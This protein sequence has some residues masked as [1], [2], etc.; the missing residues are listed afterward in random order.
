MQV[1]KQI[2]TRRDFLQRSAKASLALGLAGTAPAIYPSA[3]L[4]KSAPSNKV[5]FG[6]IGMGWRGFELLRQCVRN[7]NIR[8]AAICDLDY[9][10]LTHRRLFLDDYMGIERQW[11]KGDGWDNVPAPPPSGAVDPYYDYRYVLD[12][13]DIDAVVIAVPDHWHA[14][15]YLDALDAGKDVYGEKPLALTINQGRKVVRKVHQ[16]GRI[17]QTGLQQRSSH[18][19]R[20]AC[21][22]VRNGRLGKLRRIR[23]IIRGTDVRDPVP[24]SPVP[25]GLDWEKW[26]GPAELVPYNELRCHVYFRYFYEY[27]GGQV[28]DLGCHDTDI[29]QWALGM[30]ESGPRFIEGTCETKP[31]AFNTFTTFNFKLTYDSGVELCIESGDGFDMIFYGDEGEIFVNRQKIVSTPDDILKEPL[32]SSDERLF[33]SNDHM[34]NFVDC[35]KSRERPVCD[36]EVGHRSSAVS[37][38]ANICGF[39]GRKLEWD[40]VKELFVNDLEA[41]SHLE[42]PEREPYDT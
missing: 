29:A 23:I 8:I 13:K 33:V 40:P 1:R 39:V 12:R 2:T 20:T 26:L 32:S 16:T 5:V 22:Y 19:F 36:V 10:F 38:L 18:L 3:V 17:F 25:P 31:G 6:H 37:H 14:R 30:D 4:G 15:L 7:D 42:R 41:N 28:T 35:I 27:S 34:Q 9:R 21:E 11:V 24:D